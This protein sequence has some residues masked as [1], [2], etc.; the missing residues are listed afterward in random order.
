MRSLQYLVPGQAGPHLLS[1]PQEP[2]RPF[3]FLPHVFGEDWVAEFSSVA[4]L[5]R[6]YEGL[7][8]RA[9]YLLLSNGVERQVLWTTFDQHH[10]D[11]RH[12]GEEALAAESHERGPEPQVTLSAMFQELL[13]KPP[14]SS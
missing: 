6:S 11:L 2:A 4:P 3:A 1:A 8:L 7:A 10:M 5:L 13:G 14:P 12:V 9:A